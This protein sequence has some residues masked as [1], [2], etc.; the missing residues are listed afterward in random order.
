MRLQDHYD[1]LLHVS[2]TLNLMVV[3]TKFCDDFILAIFFTFLLQLCKIVWNMNNDPSYKAMG[4]I[5]ANAIGYVIAGLFL[6]L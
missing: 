3:F 4:D 6:W 1:K 2:I 5:I